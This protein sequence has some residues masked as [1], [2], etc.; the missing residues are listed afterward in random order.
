MTKEIINEENT[1][2]I[3][4]KVVDAEVEKKEFFVIRGAKAVGGAFKRN[5]KPLT[6]GFVAGSVTTLCAL[7]GVSVHLENKV[8]ENVV[9]NVVE[10]VQ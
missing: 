7:V 2:N 8:V 5:W 4:A 9:T 6:L 10:N 3:K 1:M